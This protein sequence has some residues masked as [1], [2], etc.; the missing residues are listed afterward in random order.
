MTDFKQSRSVMKTAL[1]KAYGDL[2]VLIAEDDH[3]AVVLERER[4]KALYLEFRDVHTSYH[5][6]I[7]DDADIDSS[8]AFLCDVQKQY[9]KEQN[10]A[11]Q[12]LSACVLTCK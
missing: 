4:I 3:E 12:H 1:T 2:G 8:D 10:T 7:K 9:I 6:T 11:K 5:E